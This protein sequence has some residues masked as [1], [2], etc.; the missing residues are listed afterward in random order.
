MKDNNH[1][2]DLLLGQKA[3]RPLM[4]PQDAYKLL[5]QGVFGVGHILGENVWP[6][7]EKEV[8]ELNL[9]DFKTESLTEV[10]SIDEEIVRINLRPWIRNGFDLK[11]LY[12]VMLLS[13]V[14]GETETFL[15]L[16]D[17]F[18]D[19]VKEGKL[20]FDLTESIKLDA[21][22]DRNNPEAKHHSNIYRA[23]YKPA[24]RVLLKK[25]VKKVLEN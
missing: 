7:L 5:F 18:I 6:Y 16:W 14:K 13:D 24:Y 3:L 2:L 10:I 17:L 15:K 12:E 9:N 11:S 8:S 22:L 4:Q 23:T 1:L 25:E 21:T 19:L 20:D